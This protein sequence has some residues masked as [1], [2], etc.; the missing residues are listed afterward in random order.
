M[1][2]DNCSVTGTIAGEGA[3][4]GLLGYGSA[5]FNEFNAI[6]NSYVDA[7]IRGTSFVGGIVGVMNYG[8]IVS[9]YA[10]GHIL[11]VG[12]NTYL[13]GIV[14]RGSEEGIT[15]V[16]NS[17]SHLSLTA[18]KYVVGGKSALGYLIGWTGLSHLTDSYAIDTS[19]A[20]SEPLGL[21]GFQASEGSFTAGN[22]FILST[23]LDCS[24][25]RP[26]GPCTLGDAFVFDG[27]DYPKV[28][29][30]TGRSDLISSKV[31]PANELVGGQE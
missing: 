14:G 26:V 20:G 30:F 10:K 22:N 21:I 17:Y 15:L 9:S 31:A 28:R 23:P 24:Q 7:H 11:G 3:V 13:G 2:L 25:E 16:A 29:K 5:N 19:N 8:K 6:L 1:V 4:G 27:G 18:R 12:E